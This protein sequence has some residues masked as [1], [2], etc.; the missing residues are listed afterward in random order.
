[1]HI[2]IGLQSVRSDPSSLY[3]PVKEARFR[4]EWDASVCTN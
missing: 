3:E 1:M 2:Y 4:N